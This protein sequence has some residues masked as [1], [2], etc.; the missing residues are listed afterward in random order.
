MIAT[1]SNIAI[2]AASVLTVIYAGFVG[3]PWWSALLC[4]ATLILVLATTHVRVQ[5]ELAAHI[6]LKLMIFDL[7]PYCF[8]MA[9]GAFAVGSITR[10]FV[11]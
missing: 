2:A 11:G 8:A 5:R 6:S 1:T 3:S 4:S 7:G 10:V 9:F